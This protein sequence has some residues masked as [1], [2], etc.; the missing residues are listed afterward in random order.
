VKI[1]NLSTG[2]DMEN[3]EARQ[4][5]KIV[6]SKYKKRMQDER[7]DYDNLNLFCN[8]ISI[9]LTYVEKPEFHILVDNYKDFYIFNESRVEANASKEEQL[10]IGKMYDYI[11]E[12]DYSKDYFNLFTTSLILHSKLYSECP[13]KEFGGK[14]RDT[15]A[16][17]FDTNYE[18]VDATVAKNYFNNLIPKSDRIFDNLNPKTGNGY[19]AYIND[20]II[21]T[22]KLIE[23]Q[24]FQDG[25]KRVFRALLNLLLKKINIPPIYIEVEEREFYKDAL[26][27]AIC[28]KNYEKIINFYYYKVCDAI[29][30]LDIDNSIIKSQTLSFKR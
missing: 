24:P 15:T 6:F 26:L 11:R 29:I 21:E 1:L 10:G 25:N 12:F 9:Y 4:F 23:I 2:L 3:K 7:L 22:T 19:F 27:T 28:T 16:Y 20:C 14:L 5:L 8:L 13:C 17:L 30:S 18:V